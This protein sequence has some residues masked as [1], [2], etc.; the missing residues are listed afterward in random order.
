[1]K[2]LLIAAL[3]S[4]A[5][6]AHAADM[7]IP[8]GEVTIPEAAAVDVLAWLDTQE[9]VTDEVVIT[10]ADNIVHTADGPIVEENVPTSTRVRTVIAE[11]PEVK[12][13][14]IIRDLVKEHIESSVKAHKVSTARAMF[15][16]QLAAQMAA[17]S[18]DLIA[19]EVE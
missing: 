16:A 8:F 17:E 11:T 4:L 3:T 5:I 12:L 14:R 1:M 15:E 10:Y 7:V 18:M 19:E 2:P 9:F 13:R 6:T